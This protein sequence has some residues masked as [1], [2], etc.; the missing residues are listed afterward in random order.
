MPRFKRVADARVAKMSLAQL[1]AEVR[2]LNFTVSQRGASINGMYARLKFVLD[3]NNG[4]IDPARLVRATE[5][6]F[7]ARVKSAAEETAKRKDAPAATTTTTRNGP[8]CDICYEPFHE[9]AVMPPCGHVACEGCV[10][11]TYAKCGCK[12]PKCQ[13]PY[14]HYIPV[15]LPSYTTSDFAEAAPVDES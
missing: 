11:T 1:Q 14:E 15:H 4:F 13:V 7:A 2:R 10:L 5:S 8:V 12:C 3:K 6:E 9:R